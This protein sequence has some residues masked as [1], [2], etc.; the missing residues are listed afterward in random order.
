MSYDIA[1]IHDLIDALGGDT[2]VAEWLGIGQP[3]VGMWKSRDVIG[4]GW[5]LRLLAECRRRGLTVDPKV[6]GL[7]ERDAG[8]L[9]R[10]KEAPVKLAVSA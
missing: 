8:D 9:F 5:H 3:A 1:S 6:F 10:P 7:S 2:E 4:S